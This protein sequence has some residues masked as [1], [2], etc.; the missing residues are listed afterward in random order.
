MRKGDYLIIYC[1]YVRPALLAT[2]PSFL[3]LS[4][5]IVCKERFNNSL[6]A[7]H[8]IWVWIIKVKVVVH[9]SPRS[10]DVHDPSKCHHLYDLGRQ[11]TGKCIEPIK[12]I[13]AIKVLWGPKRHLNKVNNAEN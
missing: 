2:R 8:L 4:N 1:L 3:G 5:C 9:G 13:S 7:K 6:E 12:K 10:P 11:I